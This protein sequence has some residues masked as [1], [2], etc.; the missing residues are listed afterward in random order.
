MAA[1]KVVFVAAFLAY[2]VLVY[3]GL[4]YFEA[5]FVA[6][7]LIVAVAARLVFSKRRGGPIFPSFGMSVGRSVYSTRTYRNKTYIQYLTI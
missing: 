3:F 5:R 2:P 1:A 7:I 4:L 6:L